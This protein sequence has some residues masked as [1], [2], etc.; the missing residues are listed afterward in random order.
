VQYSAHDE[1]WDRIPQQ[2]SI[3]ASQL[4]AP[5]I[6]APSMDVGGSGDD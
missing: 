5:D 3:E 2:A 6:S 4:D 1:I